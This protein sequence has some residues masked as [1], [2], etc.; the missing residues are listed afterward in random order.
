MYL[1]MGDSIVA[2]YIL[3]VGCIWF[4]FGLWLGDKKNTLTDWDAH[5]M[6]EINPVP[7][8]GELNGI[9]LGSITANTWILNWGTL[10]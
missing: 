3:F 9:V 5:P 6:N 10:L 8:R 4:L 1:Y 7:Q 2:L